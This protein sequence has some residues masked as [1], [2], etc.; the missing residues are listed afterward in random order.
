MKIWGAKAEII[1]I[2]PDKVIFVRKNET[3]LITTP[4]ILLL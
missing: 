4:L 2:E 3:H 1:P